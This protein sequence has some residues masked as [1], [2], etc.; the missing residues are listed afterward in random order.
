MGKYRTPILLV[1]ALLPF[2]SLGRSEVQPWDEGLYAVRARAIIEHNLFWD[3][4]EYSLGG[5]Y[6]S[7]YPPLS[8]WAIAGFM[9]LLGDNAFSIR[10]FSALCSFFSIFLIFYLSKRLLDDD[11]SLIAALLLAGTTIWNLYSRQGMTD[12]PLVFF[13]LLALFAVFNFIESSE[14]KKE[15]LWAFVF[16][17]A[18]VCALMTKIIVSLLPIAFVIFAFFMKI[19]TRKKILLIL[20]TLCSLGLASLWYF[21]MSGKYGSDFTNALLAPHLYSTVENNMSRIG[22]FYY[23]N[24][25]IVANPFTLLAFFFIFYFL[26]KYKQIKSLFN[27]SEFKIAVFFLIWFVT[28]FII[29]S[30]APTK[31]PHYSLYFLVPSI[32]LT[33]LFYTTALNQDISSKLKALIFLLILTSF[34]WAFNPSLRLKFRSFNTISN[35]DMY[36]TI[37]VVVLLFGFFI[38]IL[39]KKQKLRTIPNRFYSYLL[40]AFLVTLLLRILIINIFITTGYAQGGY[41]TAEI[42]I[43]S[44]KNSFV[45]L[46]HEHSPADSLNPQLAY[47]TGTWMMNKDSVKKYYPIALDEKKINFNKLEELD[48]YPNEFI[49]YYIPENLYLA[50]YVM[51]TI[52]RNRKIYAIEKEIKPSNYVIFNTIKELSN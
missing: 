43:N 49:V 13:Y 29:F 50:E 52:A 51:K 42:L 48:K 36:E 14:H 38:A 15:Y 17:L 8:V 44:G 33:L 26:V 11:L 23:I 39:T 19:N 4:T 32:V 20:A 7:T 24:Q 21:Y 41:N 35:L 30:L 25:L 37:I 2:I 1:I 28:L 34:F 27:E 46:Y 40:I 22:I 18:F 10:L 9:K 3:Q 5:L 45:Y 6:S 31:M 16:F 12:I 47:Y